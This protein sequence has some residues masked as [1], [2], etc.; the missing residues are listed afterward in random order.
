[1]MRPIEFD[2]D[3]TYRLTKR[4]Q[5]FLTS[6][7]R[8]R[9]EAARERPVSKVGERALPGEDGAT[10]RA[11]PSRVALGERGREHPAIEHVG[12]GKERACAGIHRADM[13]VDQIVRIDRLASDLGVE[14]ET[15]RRETAALQQSRESTAAS[16]GTFIANWSVSQPSRSSPRLMSSEPKMPS[17][18]ASATSCWNE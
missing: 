8:L 16:S 3:Q 2:L 11:S 14:I 18:S 10:L 6:R 17:A 9:I 4:F 13:G 5:I 12:R 15:A 7:T 1:M